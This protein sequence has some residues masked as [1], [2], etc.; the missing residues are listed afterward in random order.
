M[1]LFNGYMN[2]FLLSLAS[3][4][5]AAN[6]SY[7]QQVQSDYQVQQEFKQTYKELSNNLENIETPAQA[8]SLIARVRQLENTFSEHEELLDQA[9][10][11]ET[12]EERMRSLKKRTVTVQNRLTVIHEQEQKLK[13]RNKKL[14][15]YSTRLAQLNSQTDSLQ[16]AI[17]KS[18]RSEKQL[19]N[20]VRQYRE[21]LEQRDELILSIVDSV[22]IA[23]RNL[24]IQ[25]LQDL[26]N[27]Q[28]R[29]RFD[30][31]G[32]AL[33]MIRNIAGENVEFLKSNPD[34]SAEEYLRMNAVHQ[35]FVEMWQ[36]V[37]TELVDIYGGENPA[38]AQK[39]VK[40]NIQEWGQMVDRQTWAALNRSLEE[41]GINIPEF[42]DRK[43]FYNG[44]NSYV[45]DAVENSTENATDKGYNRY[46][47][48]YTFW[49]SQ[50]HSNWAGY[51]DD[52]NILSNKQMASIDKKVDQWA[53]IAKPESNLLVYLFGASILA[54]VVLGVILVREKV[55]HS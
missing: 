29:A 2:I 15:E 4:L 44:L 18:V 8:D 13:E 9:L 37:G 30:A 25:S 17:E 16:N 21:N 20:L 32:N 51:L 10:F 36:K 38:E 28:K 52:A 7:A 31:D 40:L 54:V 55:N 3:L 46:R 42:G 22:M 5:V 45:T 24:D 6:L 12:Y 1:K 34:L 53:S 23:Y 47:N 35:E 27:A 39:Q 43:S 19:S 11:P 50:V 26:E 48:F 33:K 41:E 14:T 49:N